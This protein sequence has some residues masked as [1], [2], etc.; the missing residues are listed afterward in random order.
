M[1]LYRIKTLYIL[2]PHNDAFYLGWDKVMRGID[3]AV[4][5]GYQPVKVCKYV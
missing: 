2:S 1:L 4:H 3:D 5:Y